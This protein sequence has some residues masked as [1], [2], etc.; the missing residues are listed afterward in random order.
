M[1]INTHSNIFR[2]TWL[3]NPSFAPELEKM[4]NNLMNGIVGNPIDRKEFFAAASDMSSSPATPKQ[5]KRIIK[6]PMRGM[7]PAYGNWWSIGAD[8]YLEFFR[9]VNNN[10]SISAVVLDI[11]GPGSSIAAINMIKEF[12]DEKKKPFVGLS[13]LCCSGHL[14]TASALCDHHMSYGD[15]SPE[16]GS[17]GVLSMVYDDR[18]AMKEAGYKVHIIRAPQSTTKGQD[19]VDF[20][21]GKDEEFIKSLENEMEPMAEAFIADMKKYRPNIDV[22]A[23]GIFTGSTFNAKDALKYGLIDS[24]G[25]EKKAFELAQALAELQD[26]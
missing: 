12:A 23:P 6:I 4:A 2:G 15:I 22:N 17:I 25:N 20:Y 13:N 7:L 9:M 16:I 5:E 24:I 11:E 14:W 3:L 18:E 21:A 1:K 8:D 10:D 26:N 19:M